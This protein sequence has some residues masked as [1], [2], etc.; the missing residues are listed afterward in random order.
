[1]EGRMVGFDWFLLVWFAYACFRGYRRGLVL[2]VI[3]LVGLV[4][5]IFVAYQFSDELAPTLKE[6]IPLPASWTSGVLSL[7]PVEKVVYSAIAFLLLLILTRIVIR[8]IASILNRFV[9]L[10][11]LKQVNRLGGLLLSF[12]KTFLFVWIIVEILSLLPDS[13]VGSW[14][15]ESVMVHL[16]QSITPDLAKVLKD[17][18]LSS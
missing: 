3:S 10:P 12:L 15:Q 7:L 14:Y 4:L 18:F 1:M 17:G 16:I 6:I 13:V 5:G 9:Q 11:V 2:Q 8:V